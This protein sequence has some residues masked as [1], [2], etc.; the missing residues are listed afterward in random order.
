MR[1]IEDHGD[2]GERHIAERIG[3][4]ALANGLAGIA[5]WK[6]IAQRIDS[7]RRPEAGSS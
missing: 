4:C 5:T 1:V 7:I 6:V 3:S 2:E